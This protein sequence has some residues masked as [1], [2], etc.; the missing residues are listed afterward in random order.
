MSASATLQISTEELNPCTLM[1]TVSC[2][3]EMVE[4]GFRKA[5]K[6]AAKRIRIPG[7]RPGAAPLKL[8][9][10]HADPDYIR[11][12]ALDAIVKR[13]YGEALKE[14]AI[15]PHGGPRIE[16]L[17]L[18]EDEPACEFRA[19][20]PLPPK[21][22]LGD[23]EGLSAGR[24]KVE[25][26]DEEVES[27]LEDLRKRRAA[28]KEVSGRAAQEGDFAVINLKVEGE[29]GEGRTFMAVVGE[30]FPQLDEQL[31]G[32]QLDDIRQA[33]LTFPD[34]FQEPDWAGK[35]LTCHIRIKS[36]SA[37]ELPELSD[38]F[39][40]SFAVDSVE[41]LKVRARAAIQTAKERAYSDYVAEQLL[42][43]VASRS[44]VISPDP[45]WERVAEQRLEE[46]AAD[47]ERRG[48]TLAQA[49]EGAN[50]TIEQLFERL[51]EEAKQEVHR[52]LLIS[53]I[54]KKSELKIEKDDLARH[55]EQLARESG[56]APKEAF[57]ALRRSGNLDELN[58]R[59]MREKVLALLI[60][61][62]TI[63]DSEA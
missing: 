26:T 18:E 22:E 45:M 27:H 2:P 42:E 17:K 58:Y 61:K 38:E 31:V 24:P 29:E 1:L 56:M 43:Q 62:A 23:F 35:P 7:F 6:T 11:R 30:T 3:P 50:M 9:R 54:F 51:K 21:V 20:V 5:Y 10:E 19:K 28:T 16:L 57:E 8:V 36:L 25:V 60:E 55:L 59:V 44:N 49:A 13:A 39:A 33:A 15:E 32:M 46:I 48:M 14:K 4:E 53:E 40:Q 52:A 41:D 12:T 47:A 63:R 34:N 37:L